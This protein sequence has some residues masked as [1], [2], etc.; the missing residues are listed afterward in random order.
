M[1]YVK[2]LL[3]TLLCLIAGGGGGG[4]GVKLHFFKFFIPDSI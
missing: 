1:L 2:V 3:A 4:G